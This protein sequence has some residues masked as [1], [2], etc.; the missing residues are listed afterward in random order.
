MKLK[1]GRKV[2]H[3]KV[4]FADD[5]LKLGLIDEINSFTNTLKSFL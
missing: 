4:W 2:G 3:R 5:A 1:D